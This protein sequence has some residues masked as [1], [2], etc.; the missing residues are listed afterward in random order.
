MKLNRFGGYAL[1]MCITMS[2]VGCTDD[3]DTNENVPS[4]SPTKIELSSET[5]GLVNDGNSFALDLFEKYASHE[6]GSFFISPLSVGVGMAMAANIRTV[7]K[8]AILK[9]LRMDAND[10]GVVN[11]YYYQLLRQ[12]P[13]ADKTTS[14]NF[15]NSVWSIASEV[16]TPELE[17]VV[18]SK[19]LGE[20]IKEN[21]AAPEG[22]VKINDWVSKS[23]KGLIPGILDHPLMGDWASVNATYFLGKWK[24]KFD[25]KQTK[26]ALFHNSDGTDVE[27]DFMNI[28]ENFRYFENEDIESISMPYGNQNYEMLIIFPQANK[29]LEEGIRNLNGD[30]VSIRDHYKPYSVELSMPKFNLDTKKD[31]MHLFQTMGFKSSDSSLQIPGECVHAARIKVDE[32]GTE[33]V[34]ATVVGGYT[35]AGPNGVVRMTLDREFGFII[36]ETTTGAILFVGRVSDL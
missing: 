9:L 16:L 32:E 31:L 21:P 30:L 2:L 12:L 20:V 26:P 22:Y 15:A 18:A 28:T 3:T 34:A 13:E 27:A 19:Y 35:S 5:R 6:K 29:S 36:R 1:C 7:D 4:S 11:E 10:L 33:A 8:D 24:N 23:T 17:A 14:V 25:K